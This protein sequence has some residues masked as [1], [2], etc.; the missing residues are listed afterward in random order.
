[1]SGSQSSLGGAGSFHYDVMGTNDF[2]VGTHG[3]DYFHA[4]KGDDTMVG[5]AGNDV[6]VGGPGA[7][8][9]I[10]VGDGTDG[11]STFGTDTIQDFAVKQGD[12]LRFSGDIEASDVTFQQMSYGC[13]VKVEGHGAIFLN[14]VVGASHAY[15]VFA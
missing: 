7:D 15:C 9:Y 8:T 12:K 4:G 6:F 3:D 5:G 10:F 14:N 2:M 13:Y 11:I 1:M